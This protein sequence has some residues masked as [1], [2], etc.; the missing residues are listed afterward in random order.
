MKKIYGSLIMLIVICS[1]PFEKA[2]AQLVYETNWK[3]EADVKVFVS[4]WKSEADLIVFETEWKS[5]AEGKN[6]GVWHATKWKSEGKKIYFTKWK[7][8]ADIIIYYTKWKS[9]AR[10]KND[11]K[12]SLLDN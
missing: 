6:D 11:K 7:S 9:E 4:E 1:V 12:K 10:W 3:S 8:E 5:D 2:H